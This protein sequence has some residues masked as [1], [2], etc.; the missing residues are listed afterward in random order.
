LFAPANYYAA[1][2]T[3]LPGTT[4]APTPEILHV[5]EGGV[6][7]DTPRLYL[8]ADYYYQKI[9]DAFAFY[10]NYSL[11]QEY[12]SNVQADLYRGV[13]LSGE[14]RVTPALSV[15]ANGSYINTDYLKTNYAFVTLQQDQYGYGIKGTPLSNVPDWTSNFGIDYDNGPFSARLSAQYTGREYETYDLVATPLATNPLN[16]ATVTNT[17]ILNPA[18]FEVNLLLS[19]DIPVPDYSKIK[20]LNVTLNMQNILDEHYYVYRY[21]SDTADAGVYS[22]NPPFDSGLIGPPRSFTVDV[23]AKF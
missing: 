19:Y 18:N 14:F 12:Y 1:G 10:D 20:T 2:L 15:Y 11:D 6:R 16:G 5:F 17:A 8:N 13:E 22:I 21:S 23:S 9:D 4:N 3:G 7:Y